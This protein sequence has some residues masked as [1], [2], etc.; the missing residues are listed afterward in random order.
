MSAKPQK[1]DPDS[2][3]LLGY[4][5][6]QVLAAYRNE[7]HKYTIESDYFEG[8]IIV[9]DEYYKELEALGKSDEYLDI[10][11]GYRTM[12]GGSLALAAFL[13]DLFERSSAHADKW[14]AFHL[15]DPKWTADG[16]Q[17][18]SSWVRR[19]LERSWDVDNG[20]LFYLGETIK[21]I[22]G[23]TSEFV[24][25]PLFKHVVDQA[26]GFPA[27]ENSYKYKDAHNALYGYFIDGLD[28]KCI[29]ALACKLGKRLN[30]DNKKTVEALRNLLPGLNTSPYFGAAVELVSEQRRLASHGARTQAKNFGAFLQFTE[31]LELCLKGVREILAMLENESGMN[32]LEAQKRHEARKSLPLIVRPAE[33]HY[34]IAEAQRMAGKT[35]EKVAV[36]FREDIEGVHGSE[37]M[38]IYFSDG[39]IMGLD[40][41]SNARNLELEE[42]HI[43]AG[44]FNVDFMVHWVPELPNS[45]G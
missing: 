7:P 16:D 23:L 13:P 43:R 22:N 19:Y 12:D 26:L 1:V 28:K 42:K 27:A 29:S 38:I 5:D 11:F 41:G 14:S 24:G 18:F 45:K 34:S 21:T 10:R 25:V 9:T 15:R 44:D 17:R 32:G 2:L 20:P 33:A 4:F 40:T 36:G 37:A 35:V 31:D 3:G 30:V 8:R 39:S 6:P